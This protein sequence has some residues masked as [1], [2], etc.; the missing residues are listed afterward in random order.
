LDSKNH[1]QELS[2]RNPAEP[3]PAAKPA[4][5]RPESDARKRWFRVAALALPLLLLTLLELGLRAIGYGYPTNFFL[6]TQM[7][8][9]PILIENQNFARRYFPPSLARSPQPTLLPAVKSPDTCRLFIFGESAAMGDP[10]PAFGV[11]RILEVLLRA[12]YPGKKFEVVNVAVTAINSHVIRQ[13]AKDCA[14]RQGDVWIIYMGH[15]EVVGPFGAGTV[16]GTQT[17]SLAFI[18]ANIALKATR[19]GQWLDEIKNH[20]G[21]KASP[22]TSWEGMEMFL[23]QQIQERDPRMAVVYHHFEQNLADILKIGSASGARLLLCTVV[24]NLKDCPPFAAQHRPDLT[25]A[26]RAE[27]DRLFASAAALEG[28]A[29]YSSALAQYQ[30]AERIDG[31]NAELQ[32]RLG[33]CLWNLERFGEARHSFERA[34]DFDTLRFRADGRINEIIRE[35]AA[36]QASQGLKLLDAAELFVQHSPHGVVGAEFLYEHVH[37]NFDGNYLLARALAEQISDLLPA[38]ITR[39]ATDEPP[40]LTRDECARRLALT[41]WD[42]FQIADEMFN[43]LQRPPFATQ[44]DQ[45]S[46]SQ[47]LRQQ[48]AELRR[49]LSPA[50]MGQVIQEYREALALSP[51]DWVLRQ[52]FAKLLEGIGDNAGAEKEWRRVLELL[53]HNEQAGYS[54][55]NVLDA[56]GKSMEATAF[57]EA[58]LRRRPDS[59]E[60]RNG[61]GLALAAQGK[62]PQAIAQYE[63]ALRD[64]PG[65]VEARVN[66]GQLLAQQGETEAALA[67]YAA[68]LRLNSNSVAAHINLGKLLAD[69]NEFDDAIAQYEAAV[70]LQPDNAV[71]QYDLGNTLVRAGRPDAAAHYAEAVRARPDFVDARYNFAMELARQGRN[72]DAR[73]QFGEVVRL[74]PD[75]AEAHL[76]LGVALAKERRFDEAIEHFRETLRRDPA[77]TNAQRY[78]NQALA[79]QQRKP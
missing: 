50:A 19:I 61:L 37:L 29:N 6:K 47:R 49:S 52:N 54:L 57:F 79:A 22:P 5:V 25:P 74:R 1:E 68:A 31:Q 71:A 48:L 59:P 12:R 55:G 44:I 26:R 33:R 66:L 38:T 40:L 34:R 69:R 2:A 53:P 41:D 42:R 18:R 58:A 13:I 27:W 21:G 70:R 20:L 72:A 3:R 15:N 28:A 56:Q 24:S 11:G 4:T 32:F 36:R 62:I 64:R 77:H 76:N 30:R 73:E 45:L 51:D 7:A 23:D 78:L 10:E 16:F 8:G 14:P 46:R 43:R 60:T 39:S 35:V 65:A 63:A 67:Q 75:F 17:P 9:R